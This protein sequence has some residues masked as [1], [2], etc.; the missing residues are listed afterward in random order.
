MGKSGQKK[1]RTILLYQIQEFR[2]NRFS[3][4]NTKISN[5]NLSDSKAFRSTFSPAAA[6]RNRPRDLPGY[7]GKTLGLFSCSG[8]SVSIVEEQD[9]SLLHGQM[10]RP[11]G[12]SPFGSGVSNRASSI[13]VGIGISKGKQRCPLGRGIK[14]DGVPLG[15]RFCL[16][17]IVCYTF[18]TADAGKGLSHARQT[19]F[20]GSRTGGFCGL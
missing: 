17:S 1:I 6:D 19:V 5:S 11:E 3:H 7:L 18:A 10:G 9:G 13:P 2:N 16:Q 20:S 15:T 8:R 14:G 4:L 12:Q